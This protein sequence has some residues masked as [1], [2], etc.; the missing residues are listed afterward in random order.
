MLL[1]LNWFV[2]GFVNKDLGD[3]ARKGFT[4]STSL[5]FQL[6]VRDF[7]P[8]GIMDF[9]EGMAWGLDLLRI[10]FPV[11]VFS[12]I[13]TGSEKL[14]QKELRTTLFYGAWSAVAST[15]VC[16]IAFV[17]SGDGYREFSIFISH[18]RLSLLLCFA[19]LVFFHY[20]THSWIMVL[21]IIASVWALYVINRLGSI[22]D[23]SSSSYWRFVVLAM[24]FSNSSAG[25]LRDPH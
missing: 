19:I 18:I 17:P 16:F 24:A 9:P 15:I 20:R 23:S 8:L 11:V 3:R 22:Q 10:L 13:L 14:T 4:S 7:L 5:V 1:A 6:V 2:E 12:V 25:P 21:Q